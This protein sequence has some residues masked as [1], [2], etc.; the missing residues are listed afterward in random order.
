M[1]NALDEQ[2]FAAVQKYPRYLFGVCSLQ[3]CSIDP[4]QSYHEEC[5]STILFIPE[6]PYAPTVPNSRNKQLFWR[7]SRD[8]CYVERRRIGT[9][10]PTSTN[11]TCRHREYLPTEA[12]WIGGTECE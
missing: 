3:R 4:M 8:A 7:T 1:K 6:A 5:C 2:L 11:G 12:P 10:A 9:V